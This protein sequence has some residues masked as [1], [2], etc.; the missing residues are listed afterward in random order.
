MNIRKMER[1]HET[2]KHLGQ[3]TMDQKSDYGRTKP[4]VDL[5]AQ[6]KMLMSGMKEVRSVQYYVNCMYYILVQAC[7]RAPP[8]VADE[9]KLAIVFTYF[10]FSFFFLLRFLLFTHFGGISRV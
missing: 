8:V 5:G 10:P 7:L 2:V 6:V 4:N 9:A 3:C 1:N